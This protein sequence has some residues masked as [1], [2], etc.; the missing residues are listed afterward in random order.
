MIKLGEVRR[1]DAREFKNAARN[2]H[3]GLVTSTK[4]GNGFNLSGG[5]SVLRYTLRLNQSPQT[6]AI[7]F[8]CT[9]RLARKGAVASHIS[10]VNGD[11]SDGR[12]WE[13][14]A[15]QEDGVYTLNGVLKAPLNALTI[16][17][18]LS[19]VGDVQFDIESLLVAPLESA[20]P[21]R[22]GFV[23]DPWIE[24]DQP[25]WKADY[26]WWFGKMDKSLRSAGWQFDVCYVFSDGVA[27]LWDEFK[28]HEK[29]KHKVLRTDELKELYPDTQAGIV[30]QRRLRQRDGTRDQSRELLNEKLAQCFPWEPDVLI[31][32]SDM[33]ILKEAYPKALNLYRDA[34][35][36]REPFQDELT[37]LDW[38]GLYKNSGIDDYCQEYQNGPAIA[39]TFIEDFYPKNPRIAEALGSIG[40]QEKDFFLLPLQDSR[41]YNFYDEC[42]FVSQYALVEEV[43]KQFP[44]EKIL[45]VQHPDR[46]ELTESEISTL[47]ERFANLFYIPVLETLKNPSAQILP[48]ASAIV[49][50]STGLIYQA[51]LCG[52][53]VHFMGENS[54]KNRIEGV[55]DSDS[56]RQIG[57]NLLTKCY[58]SYDYLHDG[59]WLI[60]RLCALSLNKIGK[61]A[62]KDMAIDLP[63]NV[64]KNLRR[65]MRTPTLLG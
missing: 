29:A 3:S 11:V 59:N 5:D 15:T 56:L 4:K 45:I 52:I 14:P 12:I 28:P 35:Y 32:M 63:D 58:A 54:L 57:Y 51:L 39:R 20:R 44:N 18:N 27:A 48:F 38:H 42:Q 24:R 31:S 41:H 47:K 25:T 61:L 8:S 9:F 34:L 10:V 7:F 6:R 2:N 33:Q 60:A 64:F 22:L 49:G 23:I 53:P 1:Y 36:C 62:A 50:I 55:S 30:E 65:S 46:K 19:G 37:S 43:V 16:Y 40:L 21:L 26:I 13:I 17:M